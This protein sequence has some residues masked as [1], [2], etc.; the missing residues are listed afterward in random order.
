M[1]FFASAGKMNFSSQSCSLRSSAMPRNSDMAAC[2]WVL[3]RPGARIASGRSR[4]CFAWKRASISAFVPTA[5]DAVAA[6]GHGAVLDH[7]ALRVHGDDVARAP[8]PVGRFGRTS[9]ARTKRKKT[10]E[11]RHRMASGRDLSSW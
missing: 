4:R 5:D 9:A 7:A 8:D 6:D 2:V 10:T 3:I 11:T 1:T